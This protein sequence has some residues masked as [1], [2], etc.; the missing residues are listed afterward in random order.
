MSVCLSVQV[1]ASSK[2]TQTSSTAASSHVIAGGDVNITATGAGTA[3]DINVIGSQVKA[4]DDVTLKAD[5]Q[6]NLIA[7]QN[8]DTLKEKNSGSSASIGVSFGTDGFLVTA[9]ASGS[10]RQR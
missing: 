10:K 6:I 9:S 1:K 8:V 4:T 5:D 2:T 3:S 7:A